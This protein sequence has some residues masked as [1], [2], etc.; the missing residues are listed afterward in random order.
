VHGDGTEAVGHMQGPLCCCQTLCISCRAVIG[1]S[2]AA[3][4]V[5]VLQAQLAD[6]KRKLGVLEAASREAL[7]AASEH[8]GMVETLKKRVKEYSAHSTSTT[9]H[10]HSA[11]PPPAPG[12]S[13]PASSW[14][15]DKCMQEVDEGVYQ[16]NLKRKQEE[17][18]KRHQ[19]NLEQ[20][21]VTGQNS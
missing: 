6:E 14:V 11:G 5:Q 19:Q 9:G 13:A 21:Q 12:A 2:G 10:L 7:Q 17:E 3:E 18:H 20:L 4:A 8:K 15:C 16:E 1:C